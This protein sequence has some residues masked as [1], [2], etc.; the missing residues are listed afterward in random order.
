MSALLVRCCWSR[1]A[2]TSKAP[3]IESAV[4]RPLASIV[5]PVALQRTRIA[6]VWPLGVR[7][8]ASNWTDWPA[9]M[10]TLFGE[11]RISEISEVVVAGLVWSTTAQAIAS[12][13]AA[14]E[15]SSARLDIRLPRVE[16]GTTGRMATRPVSQRWRPGGHG[17]NG[18]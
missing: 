2:V 14:S 4:Y 5:P 1:L 10:D 16:F 11:M 17:G 12:I 8:V 18:G 7:P 15:H 13:V 9:A 3:G 6:R